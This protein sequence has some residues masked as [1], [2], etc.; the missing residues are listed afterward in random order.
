MVE[1]I[2]PAPFLENENCAYLWINSL[3]FYTISFYCMFNRR[4]SNKIESKVQ[5]TCLYLI[6]TLY[7]TGLG[8]VSQPHFLHDFWTKLFLTIFYCLTAFTSWVIRKYVYYYCL[9]PR[10]W[11]HKFWNQPQLFYL[12]I[13]L[14]ER[15]SPEKKINTFRMER[16]FKMK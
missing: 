3:E 9:F 14:H 6:Q 4:L 2:V 7:R 13:F 11:R 15:K 12:V 10:L 8:L 16:A 5:T 1:K